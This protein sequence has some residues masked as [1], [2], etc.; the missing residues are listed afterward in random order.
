MTFW[1]KSLYWIPMILHFTL[2]WAVRCL[3]SSQHALLSNVMLGACSA[4]KCSPG[5]CAPVHLLSHLAL[6]AWAAPNRTPVQEASRQTVSTQQCARTAIY[7]RRMNTSRAHR[8]LVTVCRLAVR[9]GVEVVPALARR[10]R[11]GYSGDLVA[12]VALKRICTRRPAHLANTALQ[13]T[14]QAHQHSVQE[15]IKFTMPLLYLGPDAASPAHGIV[16]LCPCRS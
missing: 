3:T 7:L 9:T 13:H 11:S 10:Q 1:Q 16:S 8:V 2:I 6:P 14:L 12:S 5:Q 15:P 4:A